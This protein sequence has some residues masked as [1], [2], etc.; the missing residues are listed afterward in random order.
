MHL[1]DHCHRWERFFDLVNSNRVLLVETGGVVG[2]AVL[3]VELFFK[4]LLEITA[5]LWWTELVH[6]LGGLVQ[7]VRVR[8]NV[9]FLPYF[10]C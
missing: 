10:A 6:L 5:E 7:I 1:L 8:L 3:D 9:V 2:W 4:I